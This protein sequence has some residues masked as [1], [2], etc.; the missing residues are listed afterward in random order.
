M[1]WDGTG[2]GAHTEKATPGAALTWYFAEG[3]EQGFF[4][5]YLLLA[6]PQAVANTATVQFL[7]EGGSPVT[8][9]YNL[10]PTSRTNVFAELVEEPA[11]T[12][13]LLN[14]AF[15]IVVTFAQP[16]V[17]ERAMYFGTA[18]FWNGGHESAGVNDP[19]RNW[20]HAEGAT[21]SFF[22]TFILLSNPNGAPATVTLTYLLDTGATVVKTKTIPANARLTV[23]V[24]FEDALLANAATATQVA[25]DLPIVSERAMYWAGPFEAWYEAHNSFGVTATGTKWV[26]GEGRVGGARG[27]ETYILLANPGATAATV[28]LTYLREDGLPPIVRTKTVNATTRFNVLANSEGLGDGERFGVL[29]ESTQP[30]AVERAMYSNASSQPGLFWAAGTNASATRI[31]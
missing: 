14:R 13:V 15:G 29:I 28:T 17:A 6:N 22:D 18:P 4:D 5:T 2:Y 16:G 19:S 30:I 27:Y 24:E 26:L 9:T 21:G 11:G 1:T 3:S 12:K 20:F 31:P 10:L 25:S 8:K 23:A 7:I